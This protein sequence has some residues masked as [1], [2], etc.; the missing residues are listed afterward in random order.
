MDGEHP[1]FAAI[2]VAQRGPGEWAHIGVSIAG[3]GD[4]GNISSAFLIAPR[5]SATASRSGRCHTL[6]VSTLL[7]NVG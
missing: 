1:L 5:P 7:R 4:T 6:P 2:T 3:A